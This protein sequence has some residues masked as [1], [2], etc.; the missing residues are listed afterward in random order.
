M[1]IYEKYF[2]PKFL[3]FA[4]KAPAMAKIRSELVPMAEG[5]V[6]EIGIGSG[7][8]LPYYS[9]PASVTGLDPSLELQEYAREVA[10][11]QGIDVDFLS[12]SGEDIPA[13]DNSF[14]SIVMTW[15]LCT[16]PDP[17]AALAEIRR[18]L[19]PHG[20]IVFAEHGESP[21]PDVARWQ[22]RINPTWNVIGGGCN[23]NRRI[24]SL[25]ESS[26]FGFDSIDEGYIPGPKVAAYSYRGI[27]K[28]S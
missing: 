13:D 20:K 27:A 18:V 1:G 19:K 16:I 8:N 26:G 23:L 22:N 21:D 4:M 28:V 24:R 25:Y 3:N 2:L 7:L 17:L 14:D 12:V 11:E 9:N 6:L 5:H 15:T 10:R